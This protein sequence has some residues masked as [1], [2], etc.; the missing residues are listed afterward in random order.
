MVDLSVD[1]LLKMS[2]SELKEN[3]SLKDEVRLKSPLKH[4]ANHSLMLL[5]ILH[6]NNYL[7]R[8]RTAL[9]YACTSKDPEH[10]QQLLDS[11]ADI[12]AVN[13]VN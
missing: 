2:S 3:M 11:G 13:M 8:C 4:N 6:F 10:V 1:N 5:L 7:Q 9:M 12:E